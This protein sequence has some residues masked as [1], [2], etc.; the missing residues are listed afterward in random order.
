MS[1]PE[2]AAHKAAI[3]RNNVRARERAADADDAMFDE[4]TLLF[5]ITGSH[6]RSASEA[7]YRRDKALTR[8]HARRARDGL[9]LAI[10][11][12]NALPD[13]EAA[14]KTGESPLSTPKRETPADG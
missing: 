12:L 13:D 3:K 8:D 14:E 1:T 6:C 5:G 10:K 7:A 4:L 11:T 2:L 9:V